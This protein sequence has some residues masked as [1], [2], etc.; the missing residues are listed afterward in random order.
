ML[1]KPSYLDGTPAHCDHLK[2]GDGLHLLLLGM[3]AP[4]LSDTAAAGSGLF[5]LDIPRDTACSFSSSL[6]S[7]IFTPEE[8]AST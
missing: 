5:A 8:V 6:N 4:C 7:Y 1:G 3:F 2:Q